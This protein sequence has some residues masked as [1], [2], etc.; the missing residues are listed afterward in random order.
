MNFADALKLLKP[1][2]TQFKLIRIGGN[3][4]GAYLV[5]DD[6]EGIKACFSPG[7][8][9]KKYFEDEL[10]NNYNIQCHMCDFSTDE[11]L[12][13]TLLVNNKQTF[14]KKWVGTT[15][16]DSTLTLESWVNSKAPNCDSG[17]FILQMDIEGNEYQVLRHATSEL[18]S[19]FRIIILEL[20]YLEV[21]ESKNRVQH[22]LGSIA[23]KTVV[24][25]YQKVGGL[26][27]ASYIKRALKLDEAGLSYSPYLL[28]DVLLKLSKTHSC[29]H[30][31]P[32]NTEGEFLE[33]ST[34]MNVPR[35]LEVTF[36][37]KDRIEITARK[38]EV[39]QIPHPLDIINV[40]GA[41]PVYL[42]KEWLKKSNF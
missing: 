22:L 10:S 27:P 33:P 31:H 5:P 25:L 32:N 11:D 39:P 1:T 26:L 20:H 14:E 2:A 13:K 34:G 6:L 36:L 28:P 37:R 29:V 23:A 3:Q 7:V 35:V 21:F 24:P 17:D 8:E 30:A 12:F 16:N 19:K 38:R 18:I 42:N 41:P 9:S 40:S 15:N 4:D